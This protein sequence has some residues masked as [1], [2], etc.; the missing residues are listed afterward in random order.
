MAAQAS[1][2]AAQGL[3]G[4]SPTGQGKDL[5]AIKK[6]SEEF[7]AV[8]LSQMFNHMFSGI[9]SDA[10]FGGGHGEEMFQSMMIDDYSKQI[11]KHGGIGIASAVMRTMISEQEK[12][13]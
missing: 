8:Y 13:K 12:A 10:M 3:S 7:E 2:A 1:Y 5:A 9:K 11:V 4:A 6:S